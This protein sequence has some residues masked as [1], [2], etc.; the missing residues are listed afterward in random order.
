VKRRSKTHRLW[1]RA[2]SGT[3]S[4]KCGKGFQSPDFKAGTLHR[5][6]NPLRYFMKIRSEELSIH[7]DAAIREHLMNKL[8][9]KARIR[10]SPAPSHAEWNGDAGR[11]VDLFHPL[12]NG[13]SGHSD[14][15]EVGNFPR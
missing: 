5:R 13:S 4:G 2:L 8:L 1:G 15:E 7:P 14:L 6:L 11:C 3:L 10:H 9:C 12:L